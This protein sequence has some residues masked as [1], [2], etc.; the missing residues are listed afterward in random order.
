MNVP[1]PSPDAAP[2]V[3]ACPKN[4]AEA[5]QACVNAAAVVMEAP[6]EQSWTDFCRSLRRP[7]LLLGDVDEDASEQP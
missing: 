2:I 3:D 6:A 1:V 4:K 7:A 5:S